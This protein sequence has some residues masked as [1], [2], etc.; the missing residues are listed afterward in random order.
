M[1]ECLRVRLICGDRMTT[2]RTVIVASLEHA[3]CELLDGLAAPLLC[4]AAF[5]GSIAY[6]RD[7]A[8]EVTLVRISGCFQDGLSPVLD[9]A[10]RDWGDRIPLDV[11]EAMSRRGKARRPAMAGGRQDG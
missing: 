7:G 5:E 2:N 9:K 11:A 10:V 3:L 4:E 1:A 6:A 8:E